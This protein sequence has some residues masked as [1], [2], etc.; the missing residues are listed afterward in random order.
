MNDTE[1]V[2]DIVG[3]ALDMINKRIQIIEGQHSD[4]ELEFLKGLIGCLDDA[5][6]Y[7]QGVI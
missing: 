3:D 7:V 6:Q 5:Y 1:C 2:L 4:Q